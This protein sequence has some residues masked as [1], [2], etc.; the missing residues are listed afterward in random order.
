[1]QWPFQ[2]WGASAVLAGHAHVYERVDKN[3]LPYFINGL[4]GQDIHSF[5]TPIAGSQARYNSDFGAMWVEAGNDCLGFQFVTRAGAVVDSYTLSPP[6]NLTITKIAAPP[7]GSFV[8]FGDTITYTIHVTNSGGPAGSMV[9]TD[10]IPAG[11]AY[12]PNSLTASLG[13]PGFDGAQATVSISNLPANAALT[14]TFKIT[15][16]V[17]L[18]MTLVNTATLYSAATGPLTSNAVS[19]L[20]QEMSPAP[21]IPPVYLPLI[22]K[23]ESP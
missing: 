19:H 14:I 12:T 13:S 11:A 18:S 4:G 7:D 8:E 20:V 6:P 16:T 5:G 9:I 23:S 15:V 2:N 21:A 3:G 17:K 22:L 10:V 1:V